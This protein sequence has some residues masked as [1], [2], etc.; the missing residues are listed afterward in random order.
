MSVEIMFNTCYGGFSFSK[1]AMDEWH[2]LCPGKDTVR[3]WNI[4]R[5]D[6]VMVQIVKE[7]GARAN[8]SFSKIELK[9]IPLEY[10]HHYEIGEYDGLE[11]VV[12]NYNAYKIDTA[13][14]ILRD[15][16]LTKVEKLAR[17]SAVLNAELEERE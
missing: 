17:V 8:G 1:A 14:E 11:A 12:I 3:C 4:D 16:N 15:Q 6:P 10:L 5:H 13:K 7:M 2:K 9:K